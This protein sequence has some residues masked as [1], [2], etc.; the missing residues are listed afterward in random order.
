MK[1]FLNKKDALIGGGIV[2]SALTLSFIVFLLLTQSKSPSKTIPNEVQTY[3]SQIPQM[4]DN[5][6]TACVLLAVENAEAQDR[7]IE[8]QKSREYRKKWAENHANIYDKWEA[9]CGPMALL[10]KLGVKG[11]H[12]WTPMDWANIGGYKR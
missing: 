9:A 2:V 8:M 11:S 7:S 12:L 5:L 1:P 10:T 4:S 6:F 3:K